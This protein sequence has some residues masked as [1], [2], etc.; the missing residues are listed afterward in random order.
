MIHLLAA[1]DVN[2]LPG[3]YWLPITIGA[4]VFLLFVFLGLYA[5]RYVKAG[6][7]EVLVISGRRRRMREP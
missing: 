1:D 6:P 7:N 5:R 4:V 3:M 2:A